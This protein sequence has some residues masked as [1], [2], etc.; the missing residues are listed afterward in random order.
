[1]TSTARTHGALRAAVLVATAAVVLTGC[2]AVDDLFGDDEPERGDSGQ[3][4]EV[5]E[6]ASIFD[7]AEGDCLGDYSTDTDVQEVDIIPCDQDHA[8]E[9]LLITEIT[10]DELPSEDEVQ[11]QVRAECVPAFEEFVGISFDESALDINFLSPS[12]E[13][14]DEQ[15]DRDIVCTIYDPSGSVS[16]SFEGTE[17]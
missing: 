7:I 16:G 2:S 5:A 4:S 11:E 8:Q 14:W 13:S 1:M 10:G 6:N 9:V 3:V 17:R 12:Q 15:D